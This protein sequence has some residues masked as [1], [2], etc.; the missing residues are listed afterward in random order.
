MDTHNLPKDI[1]ENGPTPEMEAKFE[2]MLN[3]VGRLPWTGVWPGEKE[4][5]EFGWYCKF[6]AG[7]GWVR[8]AKDDPDARPDLNRLAVE[9]E[10]DPEKRRYVK[11]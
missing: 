7:R 5:T 3:E 2:T 8:C 9:A 6:I 10:W 1:Y 4:C 11:K